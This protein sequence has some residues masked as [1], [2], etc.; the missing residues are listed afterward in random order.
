[1]KENL[2]WA[3]LAALLAI[4]RLLRELLRLKDE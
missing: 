4:A 3:V 1:M 2:W